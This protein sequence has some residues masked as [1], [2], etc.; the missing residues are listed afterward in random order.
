MPRFAGMALIAHIG[1]AP[2]RL[3]ADGRSSAQF[4]VIV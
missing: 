2:R 1:R 3:A 4:M